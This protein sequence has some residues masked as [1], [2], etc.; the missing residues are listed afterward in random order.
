M[1]SATKLAIEPPEEAEIH[2]DGSAD[3]ESGERE[4]VSFKAR[5]IRD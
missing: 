1:L 5:T 4:F 3:N 2:S